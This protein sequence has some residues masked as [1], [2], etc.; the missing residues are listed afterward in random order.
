MEFIFQKYQTTTYAEKV[1]NGHEKEVDN[2][3]THIKLL[4]FVFDLAQVRKHT[5]QMSVV[6]KTVKTI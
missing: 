2:M 6:L 3:V 1:N 5:K 4:Y